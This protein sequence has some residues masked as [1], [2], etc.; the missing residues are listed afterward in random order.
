MCNI[1]TQ[2]LGKMVEKFLGT[3]FEG[4]ID[5]YI[6]KQQENFNECMRETI[7][8]ILSET[9]EFFCESEERKNTWEVV[10]KGCSKR[11]FV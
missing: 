7:E 1:L 3:S 9:D 2:I 11:N 10:K 6:D 5:E 4:N 8:I